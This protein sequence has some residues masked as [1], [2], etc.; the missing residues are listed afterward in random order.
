[1][2]D[3]TI[4]STRAATPPVVTV[5]GMP[6]SEWQQKGNDLRSVV[7]GSDA[8][9]PARSLLA[10]ADVLLMGGSSSATPVRAPST[11]VSHVRE[12][13]GVDRR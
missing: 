9:P 12:D 3:N 10:L 2:H 8:I 13:G 5:C 7:L 4:Y 1:M 6:L 11:R